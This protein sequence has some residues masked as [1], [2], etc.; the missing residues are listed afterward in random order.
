MVPDATASSKGTLLQFRACLVQKCTHVKFAGNLQQYIYDYSDREE[1]WSVEE[2]RKRLRVNSVVSYCYCLNSIC[3]RVVDKKSDGFAIQNWG[4]RPISHANATTF[5]RRVVMQGGW[6]SAA[7]PP[8][9]I[10]NTE[11]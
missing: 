6:D 5:A 7:G 8:I 3:F 11:G 2:L 10:V 1:E 9:I 4:F